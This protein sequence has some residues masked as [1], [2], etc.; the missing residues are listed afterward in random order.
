M[1]YKYRKEKDE[2]EIRLLAEF[3][4]DTKHKIN[5]TDGI[6]IYIYKVAVEYIAIYVIVEV[7]Y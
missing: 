1:K 3:I 5:S 6:N 2:A 7:R 4:G